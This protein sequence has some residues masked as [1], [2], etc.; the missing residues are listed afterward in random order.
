MNLHHWQLAAMLAATLALAGCGRG[1]ADAPVTLTMKPAPLLIAVDAEGTLKA[2]SATPLMVPGPMWSQRQLAM[3]VADG[4][5]VKQGQVVARFTAAQSQQDLREAELDRMRNQLAREGKQAE[6]ATVRGKLGVDLAEVG[7]QLAI[8]NRYASATIEAV[9]RNQILDAVQDQ[10]YLGTRQGVLE[11][12][13][14]ES[15]VRGRAELGVVDAKGATLALKV[16]QAHDNVDAL[17][18]RAPHDGVVVLKADWSGQ[19]PQ[20]GASFYAGN[21]LAELPDLD[22]LEVELDVPQ[23]EAQGIRPGM[24]VELHPLGAPLQAVRTTVSWVAAAA[25]PI[26]RQSPVKYLAVKATVPTAEAR[27]Y[28]WLPGMQFAARIVLADVKSALSVP[29]IAL[30]DHGQ[31]VRVRLD[32]DGRQVWQAVTLGVRGPE[33]SEVVRGLAPGDRVVLV[34]GRDKAP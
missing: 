16:K 29:N 14:R 12:R 17:V 4:S 26:S 24:A 8:A 33:R 22:H 27:R 6:L 2:A 18:L 10:R 21:P 11:W 20:V 7:S 13:E 9:A 32:K 5:E 30:D 34:A 31:A 1:G 19:K 23:V 28:G 3:V 15:G 25:A